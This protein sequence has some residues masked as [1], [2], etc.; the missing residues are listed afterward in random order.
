MESEA[1]TEN[2]H[3]WKE[4]CCWSSPRAFAAS[5]NWSSSVSA[6]QFLCERFQDSEIQLF[7]SHRKNRTNRSAFTSNYTPQ[8]ERQRPRPS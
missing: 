8:Q 4:S 5:D 7:G 3:T 1:S 6:V 2:K